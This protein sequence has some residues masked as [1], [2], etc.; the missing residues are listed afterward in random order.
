MPRKAK[1]QKPLGS[2]VKIHGFFRLNIVEDSET[3]PKIVGDSGWCENLITNNG[4]AN[5]IVDC[6]AGIS[7]SSQIT[8]AALGTGTAPGATDTL[9]NGEVTDAAGAR[10]AT[11]NTN[12]AS[13][14]A[15]FAF[16]LNSGVYTTTHTIQNV[17]LFQTSTTNAG[18]IYAGNTYSTSQLQSNQAV[19]GTYQLRFS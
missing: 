10:C 3:G 18:S 4:F 2:E 17:G 15:Q 5:G 6:L 11:T 7:G 19:N 16:T 8:Y 1:I 14:T 12:V 9:L 13:K